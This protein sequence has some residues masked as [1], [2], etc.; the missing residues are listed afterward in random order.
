MLWDNGE[1]MKALQ[2]RELR[3]DELTEKLEDL[4]KKLFSLRAQAVTEKLENTNAV[5]N[6]R[7]DIA[8]VKTLMRESELKGR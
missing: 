1:T 2:L 5:K 8:R 4:H 7:R 3:P 6:V